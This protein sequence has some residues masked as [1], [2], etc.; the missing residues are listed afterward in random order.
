[1]KTKKFF[2]LGLCS[3]LLLA[4]LHSA[5]PANDGSAALRGALRDMKQQLA[6][7][8][9]DLAALQASQGSVTD[10]NKA[11]N[12]KYEALKKQIV[13]DRT[14][15]DKAAASLAAQLAEQKLT[16]ARLTTSLEKAKAEGEKTAQAASI[17]EAQEAKLT[18]D[19]ILLERRVAD[20][21]AKNLAL[22]L[23]A[24]EILSRYEEFSLGNA[25]RAKEPFVGLTRTKLE[26]LVQ[27]YQDKILDQRIRP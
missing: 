22:F 16:I 25:I 6:T 9:S 18:N 1:M 12:A 5:E 8:Q 27:T 13:V 14:T 15:T 24:N 2:A 20:R 19:N 7:A 4:G 21:E 11:I 23:V 17:A 10:E 26:N 3:L